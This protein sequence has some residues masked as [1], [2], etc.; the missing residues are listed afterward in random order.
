MVATLCPHA[1]FG[2]VGK[3]EIAPGWL[4]GENNLVNQQPL[5]NANIEQYVLRLET[6]KH[7]KP[8]T[9]PYSAQR[10]NIALQ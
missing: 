7:P 2:I 9:Y 3:F 10:K 4:V 5:S 6:I 8:W 1:M